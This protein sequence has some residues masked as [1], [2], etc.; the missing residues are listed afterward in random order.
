MGHSLAS[1]RPISTSRSPVFD[2][3]DRLIIGDIYVREPYRGTGLAHKSLNH[4]TK[5][6][7]NVGCSELALD[8]DVNNERATAFYEKLGFEIHRHRMRVAANEI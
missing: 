3:P 7:R 4:A 5:R 2:H 8:V 1:L 6:A